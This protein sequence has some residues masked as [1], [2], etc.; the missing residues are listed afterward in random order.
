MFILTYASENDVQSILAIIQKAL[1]LLPDPSWFIAD[2]EEFFR[3]HIKEKGFTLKAMADNQMA[4]FLTVRFPGTDSDNLLY[5]LDDIKEDLLKAAHIESCV[6]SPEYRGN[7]LEYKLI[8]E[9]IAILK[10]SPYTHLLGTAHP[11]NLASVKSFLD[12]GFHI[13]KTT[14]KYGGFL[15]HILHKTL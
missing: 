15:R 4:A 3:S 6:V 8:K 13:A 7:H 1:P 11:D 5:S 14:E 9:A 2:S 12:N 10:D